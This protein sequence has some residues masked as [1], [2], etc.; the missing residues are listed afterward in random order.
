MSIRASA[1]RPAGAWFSDEPGAQIGEAGDVA[2]VMRVKSIVCSF[3][4]R[5]GGRSLICAYHSVGSAAPSSIPAAE[6]RLQM[7]TLRRSYRMVS[8]PD[9]VQ[10]AG[11][12][13]TGLAAVTFDDGYRDC[14]E[15]AFPILKDL[16]IPFSVFVTSGFVQSGR[17]DFSAEYSMLPALT[18]RQIAEMRRYDVTIG[19]HTHNHRRWSSQSTGDLR[20][21]LR[22]SKQITEDRIGSPVTAFAY[23]YGQ[24]HD[25]DDRARDLLA[26][27]GFRMA[28]TTLHTTFRRCPDLFR[29]P[30]LSINADDTL[31]DF[32]QHLTG[33]RDVL[34]L[35]EV[36]KS[37]YYRASAKVSGKAIPLH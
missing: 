4:P 35:A 9:L 22:M 2:G 12:G 28:F 10:G 21:D 11:N 29:I 20:R 31:S 37:T 13:S 19:C 16:S 5:R 32:D 17:W 15:H 24:P 23:P 6:F 8:I 7:E 33:K 30:R 3:S 25:Y 18:W 26:E 27:E 1:I 34:A 36:L 14:Y